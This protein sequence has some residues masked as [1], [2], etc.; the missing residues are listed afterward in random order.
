MKIAKPRDGE[1]ITL[2]LTKSGEP[3]YRVVLDGEPYPSG[4]RRQ[5]RSTHPTLTAARNY[6]SSHRTD[7][8]RGVLV[9]ST[10]Y[11][12]LTFA[13]LGAMWLEAREANGHI[14]PN[15]AVGYRSA[16]RR[17][18]AV[19]GAKPIAHITDMDVENLAR[20]IA[21][22]GRTQR[23]C[24]FVLFVVRAVFKDAMRRQLITRNP[25]EY[26]EASGRESDRRE[27][28]TRTDLAKLHAHLCDDPLFACWL[29][30]LNGLR[31]SE[32]MGIRWSDIDFESETLTVTRARVDVNG[33]S[34]I[35]KPKTSRGTRTLPLPPDLL[36]SLRSMQADQMLAFGSEHGRSGYLAVTVA[37][38]PVRPE[39]WTRAWRRHCQAAGIPAVSLHAARH[40]S[41][42]VLRDA[43]I[44]DHLVAAWH[45]HDEVVM[46][47][48]YSHAHADELAQVAAALADAMRAGS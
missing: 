20:T 32:V 1:P 30:T 48:T 45:G 34:V 22:D 35:G 14:R 37:G 46:R 36:R 33:R 15:T 4:R 16:L 27:A 26:V 19:F 31:R 5:V 12:R 43:G 9:S 38:E 47:R 11:E 21:M 25:A 41:V 10:R 13:Q 8:A 42:T 24:A 44:P 7:R 39:H 17:A 28:L 40:T 18:N 2:V 29:L 6:V 3:R 23:S